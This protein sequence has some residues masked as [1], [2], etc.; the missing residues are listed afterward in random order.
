MIREKGIREYTNTERERERS[1]S[2]QSSGTN[3]SG[4]R[5]DYSLLLRTFCALST[6]SNFD[7]V[8][9]I[10]FFFFFFFF[11]QTFRC[12]VCVLRKIGKSALGIGFKTLNHFL[13]EKEREKRETTQQIGDDDDV[14]V[15]PSSS[16]LRW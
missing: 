8:C 2:L 12:A 1:S 4:E 6:F 9:S 13:R 7:M 3:K 10:F 14:Q 5:E 11:S 16:A 15:V